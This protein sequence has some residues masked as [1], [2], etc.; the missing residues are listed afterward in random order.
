ML[1]GEA[2]HDVPYKTRN[3]AAK[4]KEAN[5][6]AIIE[7]LTAG[8]AWKLLAKRYG[9]CLEH[10][11]RVARGG[12]WRHLPRSNAAPKRLRM[13]K[14]V[15]YTEPDIQAWLDIQVAMARAGRRG[16]RAGE[17]LAAG[18]GAA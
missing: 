16:R 14:F 5:V 18:V 9:L 11:S 2:I 3:G 8:T 13:G 6:Q 17:G 12:A 10:I 7:A 1:G 15:Y 4:L